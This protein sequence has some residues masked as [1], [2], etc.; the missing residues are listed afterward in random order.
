MV[1]IPMIYNLLRRHPTCLCLLH[2][3]LPT[4]DAAGPRTHADPFD[5]KA[6]DPAQVC[7][8]VCVCARAYAL[9]SV[10]VQYK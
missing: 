4:G 2:R 7:V 8:C 10:Q 5:M 6:Q 9:M 1:A 3:P